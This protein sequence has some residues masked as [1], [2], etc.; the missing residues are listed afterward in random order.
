MVM[1]S[2]LG[3]TR[4]LWGLDGNFTTCYRQLINISKSHGV[5]QF[6]CY[7]W[8][9][10]ALGC[11]SY[12]CFMGWHHC[13]KSYEYTF[14]WR[15]VS[16]FLQP[17]VT[18]GDVAC[19]PSCASM[20][21]L[22]PWDVD[23]S[24]GVSPQTCTCGSSLGSQSQAVLPSGPTHCGSKSASQRERHK[25]FCSF[26]WLIRWFPSGG[27]GTGEDQCMNWPKTKITLAQPFLE[28]HPN[29]NFKPL[30]FQVSATK[31][32]FWWGEGVLCK[33]ICRPEVLTINFLL[34]T[35]TIIAFLRHF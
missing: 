27:G 1:W 25:P 5:L 34:S 2:S 15:N 7:H 31:K 32:V 9:P 23:L 28:H 16:D 21:W 19:T 12:G 18:E 6:Q 8:W 3:E 30:C 14:F 22:T 20:S 10:R 24:Q 13:L 4:G 26:L 35:I 33:G 11:F 29:C 17:V